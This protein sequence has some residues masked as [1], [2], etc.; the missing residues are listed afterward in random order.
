MVLVQTARLWTLARGELV[1]GD[2]LQQDDIVRLPNE[3]SLG[4]A[5]AQD[6]KET[7]SAQCGY[8]RMDVGTA[9]CDEESCDS[10]SLFTCQLQ[11]FTCALSKV[12]SVRSIKTSLYIRHLVFALTCD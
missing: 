8:T 11:R 12:P 2:S 4:Q 9:C 6:T 3:A 1:G 7:Y 5:W 10:A